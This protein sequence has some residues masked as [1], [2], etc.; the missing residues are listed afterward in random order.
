MD[1]QMIVGETF[2]V[3]VRDGRIVRDV[4]HPESFNALMDKIEASEGEIWVREIGIGLN[5]AIS[6]SK[7]LSDVNYF[8]RQYGIHLSLGKKHGIYGKK[9]PK[10]E[11]QRFHIDVF[12]DVKNIRIGEFELGF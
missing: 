9:L 5:H 11:L 2:T 4:S 6:R 7:P 8:E 12:L 1:F 10:E 3:Q